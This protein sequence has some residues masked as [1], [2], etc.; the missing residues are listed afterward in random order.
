[1]YAWYVQIPVCV[2]LG[3]PMGVNMDLNFELFETAV[4]FISTLVVAFMLLVCTILLAT[5]HIWSYPSK[6]KTHM[7]Q[8]GTWIGALHPTA[9]IYVSSVRSGMVT[10]CAMAFDRKELRITSKVSCYCIVGASF[11]VHVDPPVQVHNFK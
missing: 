7:Y 4:L 10:S 9:R 2:I 11:F 5:A 3:W 1:M 6:S 8:T